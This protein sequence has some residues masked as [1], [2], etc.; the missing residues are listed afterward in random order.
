MPFF[1]S[2]TGSFAG[3]RRA[4]AF[5]APAPWAPTDISLAAWFDA[6]DTGSY[7]TSGSTI[8]SITDKTGNSTNTITGTP[9][10]STSLDGKPTWSFDSGDDLTTNEFAQTDGSGNH[11]AV[12]LMQWNL[13]TN[14]RDSFWSTENNSVA[15]SSKRDYAIS[16]SNTTTF[17]GELDLDGLVSNRISSSIGNA[18]FFNT[19]LNGNTWYLIAAVF[20]KSGN[21]ISARLN[22]GTVAP[23]VNDYNNSLNTNMDLR[24]FR[25]RG[26]ERM[27][28]RVAEFMSVKDIPGTGGT[29]NSNVEKAEGYLAHKWGLATSILDPGHPYYSSPP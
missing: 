18:L 2:F 19:S 1:S 28:G 12:G 14:T 5:G 20:N 9:F 17:D 13:V 7:T 29:N 10:N 11:W 26:N 6:S 22:G 16:A 15:L 27:N 21:Q 23:P 8:T 3:G 4:A 24:L 25:N